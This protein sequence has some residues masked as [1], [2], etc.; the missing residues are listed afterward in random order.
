MFRKVVFA[1]VAVA[2]SMA[3]A[4]ATQVQAANGLEGVPAF[5]NVFVIIGENTELIQINRNSMP[6]LVNELSPQSAALTKFY[7]VSHFST[8]GYVGMTSGQYTPCEQF[9]K[10]PAECHQD[11]DNI[12]NQLT[13]AGTSW[14]EWNE[15]MPEPCSVVNAG[16]SKT[17]N[18]YVV[19]HN[20]AVYYDNIEGEGGVWSETN[21][22]DLCLQNV[23]STGGTGPND[24]S[25]LDAALESGN[26]AD[27]NFIVPNMCEDAHDQCPG[28]PGP[29][30][31]QFDDFLAREVPKILDSP[32]FG[33]DGV[34]IVTFD[35]GT[36]TT[37]GSPSNDSTP[38]KAWVTCPHPFNGGGNIAFLV[39]SPLADPGAYHE[40]AD[41]YSLLRTLEDGF[42][43]TDY[44][45]AADSARAID[46]IWS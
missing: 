14:T 32:A 8:A 29:P 19:K 26:V 33:D 45:G 5:G 30:I 11:V 22:S 34:L 15:S 41:L 24:T 43:I 17:L 6:Y 13:Q 23:V 46:E 7:G 20:P 9:D 35:E 25:A 4:P 27:F 44:L 12:F 10:K 39:V 40:R 38:C 18:H 3:A 1:V 16:T 28:R 37:G 2:T 21:K 36:S 31:Q 42:G